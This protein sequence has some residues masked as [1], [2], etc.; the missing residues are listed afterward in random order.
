[1]EVWALFNSWRSL[2]KKPQSMRANP[3]LGCPSW[4]VGNTAGTLLRVGAHVESLCCCFPP[5]LSLQA[6]NIVTL[7]G[8]FLGIKVSIKLIPSAS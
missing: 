1:M 2:E 6:V 4:S 8:F 5:E 3:A 7:C